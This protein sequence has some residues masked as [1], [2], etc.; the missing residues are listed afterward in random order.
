MPRKKKKKNVGR[1][2]AQVYKSQ[3]QPNQIE[4]KG[5]FKIRHLLGTKQTDMIK[6]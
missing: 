5:I 2:R 3:K 4:L 1:Q 6:I